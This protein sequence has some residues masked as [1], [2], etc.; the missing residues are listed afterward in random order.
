MALTSV[1]NAPLARS[2]ENQVKADSVTDQSPNKRS[3]LSSGSNTAGNAF[4]DSVELSQQATAQ[5][6]QKVAEADGTTQP[7]NEMSA[8][9]LLQQTIQASR[10]NSKSAVSAQ[11]KLQA[12]VA[13]TL[14]ADS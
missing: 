12:E 8:E 7:L 9:K 6:T 5:K 11:S 3:G 10:D 13:Q 4:G 1:P 14:L 2:Q